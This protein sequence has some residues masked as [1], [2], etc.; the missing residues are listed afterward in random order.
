MLNAARLSPAG[1]GEAQADAFPLRER[2]RFRDSFGLALLELRGRNFEFQ[3]LAKGPW[4]LFIGI[5]V[6]WQGNAEAWPSQV[7]LARFSG[8]SPRAV[9]NQA[10]M[11]ER[12]GFIRLRRERRT[13]GSER[14]FYAPGLVTLAA[15]AEFVE[16]FPRQRAKPG[17]AE[18]QRATPT[19][20]RPPEAM[21]A[22]PPAEASKELRDQDPIKLS[23]SCETSSA[24]EAASAAT[25]QPLQGTKDDEEIARRA[26]TER[27][28]RKHPAR[29]APRWFDRGELAMV[30]A[31]SARETA[32]QSYSHTATRSS[33]R[34]SRRRMDRRRSVSSGRS[35]TTS[36]TT[37]TGDAGS[38]SRSSAR[39]N[40]ARGKP[41]PRLDRFRFNRRQSHATEWTPISNGSSD[42]VG[43]PT[44]CGDACSPELA[45][46][47]AFARPLI[48]YRFAPSR[49]R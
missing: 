39:R 47:K 36:S 4:A 22:A 30:S 2:L 28:R 18:V 21:A 7:T 44:F 20:V 38:A 29:P 24:N 34:S 26:L 31:C 19:S 6:H 5:A 27:M 8:W 10:Q 13:D 41:S 48:A 11:L 25:E 1:P 43:G 33:E 37:S 23:S 32:T 9:R 17:E 35:S 3:R 49:E 40:C 46:F 16:R 15:L 45:V 12:S 42:L 14:I